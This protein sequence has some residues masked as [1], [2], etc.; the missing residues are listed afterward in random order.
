[1][2]KR[3]LTAA[4]T[5]AAT[6]LFLSLNSFAA[7]NPVLFNAA[8]SSGA[9]EATGLAAAQ[10]SACGT[11]V[12]T[13]KKGG[14][15]VDGRSS[16]IPIQVANI[17]VVWNTAKTQ[18]CSYISVDSVIGNQLFFAVPRATLEIDSS[19]IGSSGDNLIPTITDV[20]LDATVYA[21]LNGQA[22]NVAPTD[23]R[24]EDAL[25]AENR[26]LAAL[27][28]TNYS[29]LG[30]GPGP[31]GTPI[32]SDFSSGSVT[33]VA[34][35][36]S[37]NDPITGLPVPAYTTTDVGAQVVL[38]VVGT[39]QTGSTGDFSNTA[40][41]T[42]VSKDGLSFA[43][44]G[45]FGYTR[46]LSNSPGLA[47]QPLNVLLR[48]PTSGTYNVTEFQIPRSQELQSTQ[49]LGVNP[50]QPNGNPL[51]LP[52]PNGGWRRRVIGNGEMISELGNAA[53]GN[54]LGYGFWST[55]NFASLTSTARYLMVDG[56]DPLFASYAGGF[57]PS[58]VAPCPGIVTFTNVLNGSYPVWNVLT[59]T[60]PKPVPPGV[61]TLI[62]DL[63]TFVVNTV[64]DFVP[65]T[66][67]NVFRSHYNQSGKI[68]SNGYKAN[69]PEAGGSVQGAV[70]TVQSDLDVITDTGKEIIGF[71]N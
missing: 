62:N 28:T 8:G 21:K 13:K 47:E 63:Q 26:V 2:K 64:P 40:A 30:Y 68:G 50:S 34:F 23:I 41:F 71:K 22:F 48:E 29:G 14:Q 51:N 27:N 16:S 43:L 37:G 69:D 67:M 3:T 32:L 49:E 20:P 19:F 18:I 4:T 60:T 38:F 59:F 1:M 56:V 6:L 12:W 24:S 11:N 15:G 55:G 9:W 65:I 54:V 58:C 10:A 25:F 57:L 45:T 33:P 70:F 61:Q 66:S 42:N 7:A 52:G 31:I 5:F 44:N 35:A 17:W 39:Q 46:D 53:N 36:I